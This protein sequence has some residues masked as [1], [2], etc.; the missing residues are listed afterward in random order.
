MSKESAIEFEEIE[1]EI[2]TALPEDFAAN[3]IEWAVERNASDI[4]ISDD[5]R[6]VLI[7]A[8]RLGRLEPV[9]R[10]ARSYGNRLQ[11]YFRAIS[12]TG[13]GDYIR[14]SEGRGV[15]TMPSGGDVDLRLNTL[16]TLF[17]QDVAIRIFNPLHGIRPLP[18]LGFDT[19]QLGRL[20][21]LLK[22]QSGL[23]LV[24]GPVGSGKTSTLYSAIQHLNDGTRKIHTIEEPI[25][26]SIKGVHQSQVNTKA[27]VDFAEL[28]TA[29]LRH[30]PDVI[31]VGEIRDAR[32]AETAVRAGASGQLVLAT[33]HAD[34]TSEAISVM[35]QHQTNLSFLAA[36][37]IGVINQRLIR[38]LCPACRWEVEFDDSMVTNDRVRS[39]I[40]DTRPTVFRAAGCDNCFRVGFDS[41]TCLPELM[42][43][44]SDLELAISEGKSSHHLQR[45]A[46]DGGML[47]LAEA[48]QL[49][50]LTGETT[51]AEV[52]FAVGDPELARWASAAR[53]T[54]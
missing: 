48:A 24:S 51:A 40:G 54:D 8:R 5:R 50:V 30:G 10:L 11:G 14:P 44:D 29:V 19:E 38:R 47:S 31:M 21:R 7:S 34:S 53:S 25:E 37:L 23:V 39:R 17:G 27:G 45:M 42:L 26:N 1:G 32:T 28:L 15:I 18:K 12:G 4:F 16:P 2:E 46:V 43:V 6:S 33:V 41:L 35:R 36:S 49:R 52:A 20:E 13:T 22:H 3:L 9:R